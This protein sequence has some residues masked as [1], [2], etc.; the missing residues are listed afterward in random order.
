MNFESTQAGSAA[1]IIDRKTAR[2]PGLIL[3]R[4]GP[5]T[6]RRGGVSLGSLFSPAGDQL[7]TCRGNPWNVCGDLL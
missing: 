5:L 6:A 1:T 7:S 3:P 2:Q 4:Q